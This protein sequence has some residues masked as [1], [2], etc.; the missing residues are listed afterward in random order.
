MEVKTD[1]FEFISSITPKKGELVYCRRDMRSEFGILKSF[2]YGKM[3]P[4]HYIS[5][6]EYN[7]LSKENKKFFVAMVFEGTNW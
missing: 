1:I 2:S 5:K 7:Q 3:V 6:K 4:S